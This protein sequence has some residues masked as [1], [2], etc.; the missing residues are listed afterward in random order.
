[1]LFRSWRRMGLS[2][3]KDVI[4][5]SQKYRRVEDD[6]QDFVEQCCNVDQENESLRVTARDIYARYRTWWSDQSS[7]RPMSAKKFGDIMSRKGFDR[8]KSHGKM[9]YIGLEIVVSVDD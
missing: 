1:M 3:P 6:L 7:S 4:A 5:E 2:P 9:I 8:A